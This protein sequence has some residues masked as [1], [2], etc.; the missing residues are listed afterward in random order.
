MSYVVAL[1]AVDPR[2]KPYRILQAKESA[3]QI[4][5]LSSG[6]QRTLS[7]LCSYVD[8]QHPEK[9]IFASKRRL[10]QEHHIHGGTLYR[11]L[12]QLEAL[13]FITRQQQERQSRNGRFSVARIQLTPKAI[14]LLSLSKQVSASPSST[15]EIHPAQAAISEVLPTH[16][17][18][19]KSRQQL[20]EKL[21]WL[22]HTGKLTKPAIF[23][24]MGLATQH[25][26]RLEDITDR[27]S[28]V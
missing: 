20:P 8:Y 17:R 4:Q 10:A 27:K 6:L 14:D 23:K 7:S 22:H 26:K 13:G 19:K 12:N 9:T 1:N 16:Q 28:V 21:Q 15:T 24:L 25:K 3:S 11:H 18:P 2:H 5:N